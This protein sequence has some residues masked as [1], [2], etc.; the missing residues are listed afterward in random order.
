MKVSCNCYQTM[1]F[2]AHLPQHTHR[3]LEEAGSRR[4][5]SRKAVFLWIGCVFI[6][7]CV[8]RPECW[9]KEPAELWCCPEQLVSQKQGGVRL[10][11][12]VSSSH[13]GR[14]VDTWHKKTENVTLHTQLKA[15]AYVITAPRAAVVSRGL[16]C[17]EEGLVEM[18]WP[19]M[20][21]RQHVWSH[22]WDKSF[23]ICRK[24]WKRRPWQW[25]ALCLAGVMNGLSSS[26]F[27]HALFINPAVSPG[28]LKHCFAGTFF[29]FFF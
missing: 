5:T 6:W 18:P 26:S 2:F 3:S 4:R 28:L 20:A 10:D 11:R 15:A 7:V 27:A 14:S 12:L 24:R 13:T 25:L 8:H 22:C 23:H 21:C 17:R 9:L 1:I 19:G 29:F 16:M